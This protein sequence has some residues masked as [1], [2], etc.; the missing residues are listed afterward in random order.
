[1]LI[2]GLT[3]IV[4]F[5]LA[6]MRP[7]R[8]Q[9][10]WLPLILG[11]VAVGLWAGTHYLGFLSQAA[12]IHLSFGVLFGILCAQIS[13]PRVETSAAD[14]DTR[15]PEAK[16]AY[17]PAG[18]WMLLALLLLLG[19]AGPYAPPHIEAL[20]RRLTGFK[21]PIGEA[22]F[23]A[24]AST[25]QVKIQVTRQRYAASY[26]K[27]L[28]TL[29]D[30]IQREI[31]LLSVGFDTNAHLGDVARRRALYLDSA[32]FLREVIGP[33]MACAERA[34]N[35][36][37][38]MESIRHAL[39]SVGHELRRL[40]NARQVDARAE[41]AFIMRARA[42]HAALQQI[43]TAGS[44]PAFQIF[45]WPRG[46]RNIT[47]IAMGPY[48]HTALALLLGFNSN[49][50]AAIEVASS[51][52]RVLPNDLRLNQLQADLLYVNDRDILEIAPYFHTVLR[53]VDAERRKL[54]QFTAPDQK[55][56]AVVEGLRLGLE[57]TERLVKNNLAYLL[58]VHG[59]QEQTARRFAEDNLAAAGV[60]TFERGM[61]ADTLG[62]V[63]IV[64]GAKDRNFAEIEAGRK[65]LEEALSYAQMLRDPVAERLTRQNLELADRF[66]AQRY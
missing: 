37:Q 2:F 59:V 49:L 30:V 8:R 46:L 40:V 3:A 42:T 38:D 20:I 54:A 21:T 4:A 44:C 11:T 64:F 7:A 17:A 35:E 55:S 27:R 26:L 66:L 29:P 62:F 31:D 6:E 15:G 14:A 39:R 25:N 5:F 63:K 65:L 1:M 53:V 34:Q 23:V 33:V 48:I 22:V 51:K 12:I 13:T 41:R 61:F 56:R 24:V 60:S 36:H 50:D 57:R 52:L 43:V 10:L 28:N 32:R 18:A 9:Q 19:V 45:E 47:E 58:T 16:A